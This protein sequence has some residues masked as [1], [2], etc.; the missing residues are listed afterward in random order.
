MERSISEDPVLP[1]LGALERTVMQ[2]IWH[3]GASSAEAVRARLERPLKEST[4]RTVLKR[5]EQKGFVTHSL[6]NRTFI[7]QAASPPG[8]VA[9]NAVQNIIDRFCN[10]SIEEVLVGMVDAEMLDPQMLRTLA[11]KIAKAKGEKS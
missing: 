7:Y 4:V 8:R 5:L 1:D 3:H 9:A 11:K 10:G 6:D 2:L